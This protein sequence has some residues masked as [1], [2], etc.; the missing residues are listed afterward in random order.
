MNIQEAQ[1][2][3]AD[4]DFSGDTKKKIASL[5]KGKSVLDVG[6]TNAIKALMQEELDKD[7]SE[8][9]VEILHDTQVEEVEKEY[10]ADLEKIEQN[11][12]ED[13]VFVETELD[14]LEV[15]RKRVM[16]TSDDMAVKAIQQ[17]I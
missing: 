16:K 5:L 3:F 2:F 13:Q 7:F 4:S 9:G 8:A 6:T 10:K 14:K 15:V 17:S 11:I 12:K 1:E